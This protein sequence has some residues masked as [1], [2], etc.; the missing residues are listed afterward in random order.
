MEDSEDA[1]NSAYD[2]NEDGG[3]VDNAFSGRE[4]IFDDSR[5][6][7]RN[8][9]LRHNEENVLENPVE[10]PVQWKMV[11]GFPVPVSSQAGSTEKT[12]QGQAHLRKTL[13]AMETPTGVLVSRAVRD[14]RTGK[15]Q[16]PEPFRLPTQAE[17]SEVQ[18]T[19]VG[20]PP[21]PG[22]GTN[23]PTPAPAPGIPWGKVAVGGGV[24]VA[25]YLAWKKWMA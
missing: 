13:V 21:P 4:S 19:G 6:D 5:V 22:L 16:H 10:G 7:T 23:T 20:V 24:A 15:V 18:A 11:D 1:W 9:V 8:P 3:S 12:V 14:T 25:A 2:D 17:L